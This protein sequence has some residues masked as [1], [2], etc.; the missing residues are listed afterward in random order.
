MAV[1]GFFLSDLTFLTI[2]MYP[3]IISFT[4]V[5]VENGRSTDGVMEGLISSWYQ[6][7]EID[8]ASTSD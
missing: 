5:H 7:A 8:R 3:V 2:L 6:F 1:D 4:L